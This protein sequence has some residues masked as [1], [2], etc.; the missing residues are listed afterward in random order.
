MTDTS[1]GTYSWVCPLCNH[2]EWHDKPPSGTCRYQ[3]CGCQGPI[4]GSPRFIAQVQ[5]PGQAA[6]NALAAS[7]PAVADFIRGSE[8]D[9]FYD[10]GRLPQFYIKVAEHLSG[11]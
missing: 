4:T 6:F 2:P 7:H 5:R 9:P 8:C 11:L 10:D 3:G 1:A